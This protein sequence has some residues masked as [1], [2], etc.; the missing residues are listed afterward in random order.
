MLNWD[1]CKEYATSELKPASP[2]TA[3]T[4]PTY[5]PGADFSEML[6]EYGRLRNIGG[7]V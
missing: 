3:A 5:V 4:C 6:N 2:S 1:D 7:M